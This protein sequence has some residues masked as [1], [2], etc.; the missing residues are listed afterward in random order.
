[1]R[2]LLDT[3]IFLWWLTDDKKL[4]EKI[5]ELIKNLNNQIFVSVASAW[6]VSIKRKIG[7]LTLQTTIQDCFEGSGFLILD[8]TLD[9]ILEQ[10]LLPVHHQDPFDRILIAQSKAENLIFIT[11]DIKIKQ[12]S[13][14]SV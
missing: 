9:H 13:L 2:Y 14:K 7:K 5:K 10:D 1:M 12:Y 3:H 6:E 4:Q 8:I 11:D